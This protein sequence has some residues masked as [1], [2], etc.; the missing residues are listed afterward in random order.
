MARTPS[1]TTQHCTD[2]MNMATVP[3]LQATGGIGM[4]FIIQIVAIVAIFY[5]L[6]ILPQRREQKRHREM[7]GAL[8]R[9][10]QVATMGGVVGEIVHLNEELVQLKSGDSRITVERARIARLMTEPAPAK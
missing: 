2:R 10:D 8:K 1:F 9:G 5:F 3:L 6:L 4:A 7:L